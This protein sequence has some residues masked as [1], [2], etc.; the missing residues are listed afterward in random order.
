MILDD[1]AAA[2]RERVAE[3]RRRTPERT[4]LEQA[5]RLAA[6]APDPAARPF[7]AALRRPGLSFICEVKRASPSRGMIAPVFDP[8]AIATGYEAAGADAISVLTEPRWF[9]GSDQYL[10]AI[11][12]RVRTPLL[13]KDFTVDAYQVA[14]AKTLGAAAV[15]LICAILDDRQLHEYGALADRLGLSAIFEAHDAA[16]IDRA[17]AA[18]ARIVGVNN[19]NLH[20]FTVDRGTSATLRDRVPRDVVFVSESGV[21]GPEDAAAARRIG[22][23]AVL[24]GE[25]LMRAEDV[26]ARL[27]ELRG[28][29]GPAH[30]DPKTAAAQPI[31]TARPIP[32]HSSEDTTDL[33]Q[34]E[35]VR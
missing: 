30:A 13:R 7:E 8:L 2:A 20:D 25:A 9:L 28:E 1:L 24:V 12:D 31:P 4:V 23:D 22:A 5:E 15:L 3:Q 11:A 35:E 29:T 32:A 18:G 16:E 27:R 21:R 19:R 26:G 14:E 6:A 17:L 34:T 33:H 10:R